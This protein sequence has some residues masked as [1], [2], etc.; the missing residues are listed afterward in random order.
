MTPDPTPPP[1][2]RFDRWIVDAA[3]AFARWFDTDTAA[4]TDAGADAYRIDWV[5]VIP[6]IGLAAELREHLAA[7]AEL[8]HA[9][10]GGLEAGLSAAPVIAEFTAPTD[11]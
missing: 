7:A 9:G 10:R 1:R 3:K 5:R 11:L 6:F 2:R 8:I 4:D